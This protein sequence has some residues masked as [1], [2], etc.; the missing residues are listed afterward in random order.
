MAEGKKTLF[1]NFKYYDLVN[2][3]EHEAENFYNTSR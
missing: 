2:D 3:E 1:I